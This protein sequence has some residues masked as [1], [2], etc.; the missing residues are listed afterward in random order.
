MDE[1]ALISTPFRYIPFNAVTVD[2]KDARL[3]KAELII[4]NDDL[5]RGLIMFVW[6]I[7]RKDIPLS[8]LWHEIT[9]DFIQRW[10]ERCT[11]LGNNEDLDAEDY[12]NIIREEG[13]PPHFESFS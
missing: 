7:Y 9:L 10:T 2:G 6:Q 13:L 3:A 5:N 8:N 4:K 1:K 12:Y 11:K